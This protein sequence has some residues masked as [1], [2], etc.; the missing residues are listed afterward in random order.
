MCTLKSLKLLDTLTDSL[1]DIFRSQ[2]LTLRLPSLPE[3][4]DPPVLVTNSPVV[5]TREVI[6]ERI[7]GYDAEHGSNTLEVFVSQLRRK[8]EIN[9]SE[10]LLHTV[11]GVGYVARSS[12]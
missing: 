3:H 2:R 4:H 9:G 7:W 5:L 1:A 10:R 8:L 6:H 11:R 12:P